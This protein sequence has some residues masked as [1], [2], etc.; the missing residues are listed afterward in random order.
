MA[1]INEEML[2]ELAERIYDLDAEVYAQLGSSLGRVFNRDRERCVEELTHRM[3]M[4]DEG[5]VVRSSLALI[6][7]MARTISDKEERKLVMTE[8]NRILQE[9][10]SLQ[11]SFGGGDVLDK[12]LA[13]LNTLNLK[14]RF[15]EK[16]HL[17]ICIGRTYG[18][19]GSEIGFTLADSLKINY[20]DAEIFSEVLK[21]LEAEK[22]SVEDKAGYHYRNDGEKKQYTFEERAFT[23]G[24]KMTLAERMREFSRYHGLSKKDAVFFNQSDLLCEMAKKEDFIVMGRCADV[25]LTNNRIPHISIFITAPFERRIQR[26]MEVDEKLTYKQA[27]NKLKRLDRQHVGYY[28]F[29]T[30][31]EWGNAVNYDLCIN[32]ASYGI[33]GSVDLIRRMISGGEN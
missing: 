27:R 3:M 11:T 13:Q 26:V 16:D 32:S 14:N 19:G 4:R 22:D 6:S 18:C 2:R 21:R 31:R 20:Y 5:H 25:I 28:K 24:K 7:N 29:Y 15:A 17:I 9:V 12:Q 23:A 1:N 30:G 10:L 8:Y 33:E